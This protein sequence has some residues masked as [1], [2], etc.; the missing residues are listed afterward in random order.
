MGEESGDKSN[1]K[2]VEKLRVNA[3]NR[4]VEGKLNDLRDGGCITTKMRDNLSV[5]KTEDQQK[6]T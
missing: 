2:R 1:F 6:V 5:K 4:K 3:T